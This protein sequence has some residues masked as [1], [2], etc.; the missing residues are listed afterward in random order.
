[1]LDYLGEEKMI[2]E[3]NRKV[4]IGEGY[5]YYDGANIIYAAPVGDIDEKTAVEYRDTILKFVN[6][7]NAKGKV[8]GIIDLNKGGIQSSAARKVFKKLNED[9]RVGKIAFLGVHPVA[10][11]LASFSM[12]PSR[13][14]DMKFFKT[15][16]E[17][18]AWIKE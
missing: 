18:L 17:A 5:V 16:E 9:K 3:E 11:M 12:G 15:K 2:N 10:K 7:A 4:R 1:L 14:K 6:I 8:N 13:K